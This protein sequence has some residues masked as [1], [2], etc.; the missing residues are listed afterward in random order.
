MGEDLDC[1]TTFIVQCQYVL[2]RFVCLPSSAVL[3]PFARGHARH[4]PPSLPSS[5][6]DRQCCSTTSSRRDFARGQNIVAVSS[7]SDPPRFPALLPKA[8]KGSARSTPSPSL[9][10]GMGRDSRLASFTAFLLL[11]FCSS[12]TAPPVPSHTRRRLAPRLHPLRVIP[13]G[14]RQRR[15]LRAA[16]QVSRQ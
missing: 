10:I 5:S 4:D 1:R 2:S 16:P 15:F 14:R 9:F 7:L 12:S 3:P 11:L 13:A 6:K 8:T